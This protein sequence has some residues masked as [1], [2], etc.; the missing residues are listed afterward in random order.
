MPSG[1]AIPSSKKKAWNFWSIARARIF[2]AGRR[3]IIATASPAPA[4]TSRTRMLPGLAAAAHLSKRRV[5]LENESL[6]KPAGLDGSGLHSL[7]GHIPASAA[8][9]QPLRLVGHNP[10]S[11]WIRLRGVARQLLHFLATGAP[12]ELSHSQKAAQNRAE[13][14][15]R[16]DRR[17]RR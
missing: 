1:P 17:S 10:S 11:D 6:A 8:K 3:W 14:T 5:L 12:G 15:L 2:C 9:K 4:F 13:Q 16:I 7:R